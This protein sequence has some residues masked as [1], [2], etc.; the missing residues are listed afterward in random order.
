MLVDQAKTLRIH[1]AL[2]DEQRS[3]PTYIKPP[4]DTIP[5]VLKPTFLR[6]GCHKFKTSIKVINTTVL[7]VWQS[8]L[9]VTMNL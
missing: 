5:R 4:Y 1:R 2:W 6:T 8:W 9:K 3:Q 7:W